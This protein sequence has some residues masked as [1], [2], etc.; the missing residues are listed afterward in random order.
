[1]KRHLSRLCT[2][3][4]L[5]TA[6]AAPAWADIEVSGAWTRATVPGMAMGVG[7]LDLHNTGTAPRQLLA[8]SS[9]AAARVTLHRSSVDARGVAHME[10]V[11]ALP[12]PAGQ[13]V[14][15][16][17]GGL[18]LMLEGLKAPLVEGGEVQV[19]LEF[20]DG[21]APLTVALAVRPL[22]DDGQAP[23]PAHEHMHH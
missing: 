21:E 22:V 12:L 9:P 3:A 4:L 1:M 2:A 11:A 18:H 17:P 6:L 5:A 15:L 23:A 19:T 13:T 10:P 20:S 7:Y 16:A 14:H 8:A